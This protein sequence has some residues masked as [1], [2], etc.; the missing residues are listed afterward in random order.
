MGGDEKRK[1]P[2]K[3]REDDGNSSAGANGGGKK[4]KK[5]KLTEKEKEDDELERKLDGVKEKCKCHKR[6]VEANKAH[7]KKPKLEKL[8]MVGPDRKPALDSLAVESVGAAFCMGKHAHVLAD[9][10]ANNNGPEG[11]GWIESS[12][13]RATGT[14]STVKFEEPCGGLSHN[15]IPFD[16]ITLA[17]FGQGW[18]NLDVGVKPRPTRV[19]SNN[20][21][22][23]KP[24]KSVSKPLIRECSSPSDGF[25]GMMRKK[26]WNQAPKHWRRKQMVKAGVADPPM[27]GSKAKFPRLNALE[28][29][30]L[31][32]DVSMMEE[33]T[34]L[35]SN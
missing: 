7:F 27:K 20:Q 2:S 25:V 26:C 5:R 9:T 31:L 13:G 21:R 10:S 4:K 17:A 19:S 8:P 18:K 23:P 3:E 11:L 30:Q 34:S 28:E 35:N 16:S 14:L 24:I 29:A 6:E 33:C 1:L 32:M 15:D 22:V 12:S